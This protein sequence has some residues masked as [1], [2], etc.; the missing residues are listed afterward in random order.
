MSDYQDSTHSTLNRTQIVIVFISST[1]VAIINQ[2]ILTTALPHIMR[3]LEIDAN[4][5][6]WLQSVFMLVNAIIIPITAFLI[7]RFTTRKL[8]FTAMG[9]FGLGTLISSLA[10]NFAVLL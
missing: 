1:F 4:A 9:L 2:T 10:P 6:Q 7:D 5:V 8:F 3:D